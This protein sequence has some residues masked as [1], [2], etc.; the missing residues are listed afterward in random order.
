MPSTINL[1]QEDKTMKKLIAVVLLLMF[2]LVLVAAAETPNYVT[3]GGKTYFCEKMKPG[4]FCARITMDDGTILKVPFGKVDSYSCKGR[5]FE[6][7]PVKC[8]GAPEDCTALMEYITSRNGLRLYKYCEYGE[9]GDLYNNTYQEAHLQFVFFVFQEGEFYL[10][11]D[12]KN[13]PT[14]LPFFGIEVL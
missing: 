5:L 11:V 4:L 9:C 7:L 2:A 10:E 12:Q 3:T 6:R 8:E 1:K 13:A 14:V